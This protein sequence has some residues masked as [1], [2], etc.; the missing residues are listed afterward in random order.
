MLPPKVL[1][2]ANYGV[3]Q[4][5][6][7]VFFVGFRSDLGVKWSFPRETHGRDAL[8]W[9]Q[10]RS[11]DYW[12]RHGVARRHRPLEGKGGELA[13]K[14]TREPSLLSWRT[15][16]DALVGLPNPELNPT[17]SCDLADHRFQPGARSY[18]GHTGSP[19]DEPA[20]TLKAGVHGVPGGE[21]MLRRPDGS[22]RYFSVRESA[23]LQTFPDEFVFHGA[24]SET[25][26]Q[27]GNAVPVDLA[28]VV[29]K[30]VKKH[31]DAAQRRDSLGH[32]RDLQPP[33]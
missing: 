29:A 23:R 26:R 25:M 18:P 14:L 11:G 28:E 21:N 16:R 12:E 9:S 3:P 5:R 32:E 17:A 30:S 7:R 1:N 22:V 31:L 2:A 19:L 4:K 13:A 20:K 24:W 27:L 33:R 10:H 6:E 15:T 8:L